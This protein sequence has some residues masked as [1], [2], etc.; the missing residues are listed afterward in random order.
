MAGSGELPGLAIEGRKGRMSTSV[1]R[2]LW[3]AAGVLLPLAE[4][5]LVVATRKVEAFYAADPH[6]FTAT[7]AEPLRTF[8][9][10]AVVLLSLGAPMSVALAGGAPAPTRLRSSAAITLVSLAVCVELTTSVHFNDALGQ[11]YVHTFVYRRS[12]VSLTKGERGWCVNADLSN[13]FVWRLNGTSLHPKLL[14]LPYDAAQVVRGLT[15]SSSGCRA[16]ISQ[17]VSQW[18][19][20]PATAVSPAAAR[21]AKREHGRLGET[22]ARPGARRVGAALPPAA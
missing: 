19:E 14:P 22:A 13:P 16:E 9:F 18:P 5:A 3:A 15:S 17:E 7:Y 1:Q 10:S 6:W 11:I 21:S 2:A 4:V 12:K 20:N 8:A